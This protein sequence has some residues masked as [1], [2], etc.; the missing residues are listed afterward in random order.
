[1]Q[2]TLP[3]FGAI[4]P[5]QGG[6]LAAIMRGPV[7]GGAELP[8]YALLVSDQSTEIERV[9]WGKYGEEI[10]GAGSR[11][12]GRANTA[13]MLAAKCPAA[14]KACAVQADGHK[15]FYVPSLG[16]LNA[17]AANVPELFDA[18]G[19]YWTST[20]GSRDGA[21]VQDFQYGFSDWYGKVFKFRVRA[22]RQIPLELLSA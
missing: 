17:A 22:V 3:A 2:I 1:M 7:V 18:K 10:A 11:V 19:V 13:G 12:D 6:R 14:V 16:E 20:Q 4:I 21:F 9:T 8:P 15:D 5:G